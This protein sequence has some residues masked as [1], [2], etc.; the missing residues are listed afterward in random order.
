[1]SVDRS[2]TCVTAQTAHAD[3]GSQLAMKLQDSGY[4]FK[5]IWRFKIPIKIKVLIWLALKNSILTKDNL[6]KRGWRKGTAK[7]QFCNKHE[8][9][10]HLF[11]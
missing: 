5:K 3:Q 11:F 6:I 8:S 2:A 10:N 4:P 1:M 9:I 7:C